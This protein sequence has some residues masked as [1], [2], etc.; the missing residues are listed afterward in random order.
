MYG[1]VPPVLM[2]DWL[3]PVPLRSARPIALALSAQKRY[4]RADEPLPHAASK[5]IPVTTAA[6][7]NLRLTPPR[8]PREISFIWAPHLNERCLAPLST[9]EIR[10]QAA[11]IGDTS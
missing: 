11:T 3:A 10:G 5:V 2:K 6:R 7:T 8:S 9:T 4:M 1:K